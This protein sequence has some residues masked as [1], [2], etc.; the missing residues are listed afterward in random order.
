MKNIRFLDVKPVH[1]ENT[2]DHYR[3]QSSQYLAFLYDTGRFQ[4]KEGYDLDHRYSVKEGFK[5]K[6]KLRIINCLYNIHQIPT[7]ENNKKRAK[8]SI[9]LQELK[10]NWRKYSNIYNEF[11][12]NHIPISY[13]EPEDGAMFYEGQLRKNVIKCKNTE[14]NWVLIRISKK[15]IERAKQINLK[16][17]FAVVYK[18]YPG[19]AP[20]MEFIQ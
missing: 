11:V 1:Y 15:C 18:T 8:C 7:E 13:I 4:Y 2:W 20:R 14:D 3:S 5:N 17:P 19:F 9:S 12:N 16:E 10:A 6:V